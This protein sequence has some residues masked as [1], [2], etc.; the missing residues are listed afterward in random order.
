MRATADTIHTDTAPA[1]PIWREG[2]GVV[3]MPTVA[4]WGIAAAAVLSLPLV[5]G[6]A[7]A[8]WLGLGGATAVGIPGAILMVAGL[9]SRP[10]PIR[11]SS[12]IW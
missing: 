5:E 10:I 9:C 6:G 7:G 1:T 2:L 8:I 3:W 12:T 4:C 11:R